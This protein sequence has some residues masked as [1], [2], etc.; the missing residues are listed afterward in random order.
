MART[1]VTYSRFLPYIQG[2]RIP[3]LYN[4]GPAL[5]HVGLNAPQSPTMLL[6][7]ALIVLLARL[8]PKRTVHLSSQT[9][10]LSLNA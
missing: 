1:K 6:S 7:V 3:H 8:L 2:N 9:Q 10:N 4:K 5:Y